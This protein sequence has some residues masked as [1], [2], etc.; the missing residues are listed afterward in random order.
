MLYEMVVGAEFFFVLIVIK[1]Y[2]V[3]I[4]PFD[5]DCCKGK[6]PF[7]GSSAIEVFGSIMTTNTASEVKQKHCAVTVALRLVDVRLC[8]CY[9]VAICSVL[10]SG[11]YGRRRTCFFICSVG[12]VFADCSSG[13]TDFDNVNV[14]EFIVAR[15]NHGAFE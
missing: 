9:T 8:V 12:V 5:N 2:L 1:I 3:I 6:K 11:R 4:A 15:L 13:R 7:A 10:F 14:V